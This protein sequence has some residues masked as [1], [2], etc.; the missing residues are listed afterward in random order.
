MA[1]SAALFGLVHMLNPNA[2]WMSTASLT[3]VSLIFVGGFLLTRRLWLC[4]GLHWGWN[5]LQALCSVS[6]SGSSTKGLLNGHVTGP[7]WLTGGNF[8]LEASVLTLLLSLVTAGFLLA[9]A[10]KKGHFIAPYWRRR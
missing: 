1:I 6:V 5:L 4:V 9:M 3:L 8:G 7:E 10:R 2:T